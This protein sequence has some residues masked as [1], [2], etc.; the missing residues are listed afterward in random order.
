M[1]PSIALFTILFAL[2]F[3]APLAA[4]PGAGADSVSSPYFFVK[5]DDPDIDRLPLKSTDVQVT[6][7]GVIADVTVTQVYTNEGR[8]PIEAVYIFPAATRAAVY[9]LTMRIGERTIE[10]EIKPGQ[11]ARQI[12]EQARQAGQSA[13]LLEQQRPNVF[14]MNVANILPEDVITVELRYTELLVPVDGVYAFVY[15][16]VVGPRYTKNPGEAAIRVKTGWPIPTFT[17]GSPPSTFDIT[18]S[19]GGT[20][21]CR[22]SP[23]IP[24]GSTSTTPAARR[25][26]WP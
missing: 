5:S 9:G 8:R 14:Q 21:D 24:T 12:Y 4:Q 13:S 16:T 2:L 10:A 20:A 25:P 17:R 3:V 15:P 7:S 11:A 26:R 6:V 22:R 18:V 19:S 23:A 1:K